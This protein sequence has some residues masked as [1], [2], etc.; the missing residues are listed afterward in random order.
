[1]LIHT[2]APPVERWR[3]TVDG[4]RVMVKLDGGRVILLPYVRAAIPVLDPATGSETARFGA[5]DDKAGPHTWSA[6]RWLVWGGQ[7][8]P[9]LRWADL[10]I[11]AKRRLRVA[12][13]VE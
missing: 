7:S 6:G 3:T 11:G 10:A 8:D 13:T 1:M 9:V 12:T 2:A 5:D 4:E